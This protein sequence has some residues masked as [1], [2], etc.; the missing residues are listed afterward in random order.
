MVDSRGNEGGGIAVV[1]VV[2]IL[3][4]V[5]AGG[6]TIFMWRYQRVQLE[7]AAM[8]REVALAEAAR[9]LADQ[10]RAQANASDAEPDQSASVGVVAPVE[11]AL[12]SV[13][14]MQQ[15]A[16]NAGDID[17]F[18]QH[19]WQSDELTFSSGGKVTR[20][21][22]GTLD[23]YKERYPTR[24]EMGELAFSNLEVQSLGAEAAL[25]LGDWHLTR[26]SGDVGGNFSV[27]F[28]LID[29]QWVIVHDHT[30]RNEPNAEGR[31]SRVESPESRVE[32]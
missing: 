12:R 11:D 9:A 24:A 6:A 22:Q 23:N 17:R 5:P 14:E 20:S 25:V 13:L 19:Y 26:E 16:W 10:Q 1:I 32:G 30:S 21:W 27:V 7:R 29:D 3:L 8:E 28:R 18:M 4:L 15:A 2:V 31:E